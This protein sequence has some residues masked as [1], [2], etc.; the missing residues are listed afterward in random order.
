[1]CIFTQTYTDTW[2]PEGYAR[3]VFLCVHLYMYRKLTMQL[4]P[5]R[6]ILYIGSRLTYIYE[7]VIWPN[8]S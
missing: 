5:I 7:C 3:L 8:V 2:T 1:M 4:T 6:K